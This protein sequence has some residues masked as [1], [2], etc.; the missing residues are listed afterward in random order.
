MSFK[1]VV[2]FLKQ[3]MVL[4]SIALILGAFIVYLG[5]RMVRKNQLMKR[6]NES[7]IQYNNCI[8]IPISFKL[9]K[10]NSIAKS[11]P[12]KDEEVSLIKSDYDLVEKM[13]T[14][15]AVLM[16]EI[17][18]NLAFNRVGDASQLMGD[19]ESV[20]AEMGTLAMDVDGR[21]DRVLEEE[22]EQREEITS[23]KDRFR[24]YKTILLGNVS[25]YLD[26]YA[27]LESDTKAIEGKFSLFEEWIFASDYIKARALSAE[28]EKDIDVYQYKVEETPKLY[29]L[30]KGTIPHMLD[31]LSELYQGT[32]SLDVYL[33][34]LEVPKNIG[35]LAEV[36]KEDLR[37][38]AKGEIEKSQASLDA[39][40]VRLEHLSAQIEKEHAASVQMKERM[41]AAFDV[42]EELEGNVKGLAQRSA[43]VEK[44]FAFDGLVTMVDNF[45]KSVL[46]YNQKRNVIEGMVAANEKPASSILIQVNELQH[47]IELSAKDFYELLER[48]NKAS[49]DEIRAERQLMKLYLI[50]NDVEVRI[51]KRNLASIS[52][53]YQNDLQRSQLYV[54]QIQDLLNQEIL[55]VDTINGT[56]AEAI[57][58]I[59]QLHNNVNNLVGVVDMCENA[60]VYANKFR[61]F[62]PNVDSELTKAE[63]AFNNG[64]YTQSLT[65]VIKAI[66]NY[67]P[68]P[69]YEKM[70]KDNAQSAH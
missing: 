8:S 46:D 14:E 70:I 69:S 45:N 7:E 20:I 13:H 21:L 68:N 63:L 64:E 37:S 2:E 4:V 3:P 66:D 22:V 67:K 40:Q 51:Q 23:L 65:M 41:A 50:I 42:L 56:V 36:L 17:E 54:R 11:N 52:K 25:N 39:S 15:V 49:S 59:Y 35:V 55:D 16:A 48:V 6:F 44:R 47:D 9:N 58:F 31:S 32:R 57:D 28:I 27:V 43:L 62:V 38:L 29:A 1:D 10:A 26:S 5:I 30:A 53:E 61:A 60:I 19:L 18:D 34:H 12:N 33:E 24:K